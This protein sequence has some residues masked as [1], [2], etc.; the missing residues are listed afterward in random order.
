DQ[1]LLISSADDLPYKPLRLSSGLSDVTI[2]SIHVERQNQA[3]FDID[4]APPIN[5]ARFLSLFAAASFILF[6]LYYLTQARH[7]FQPTFYAGSLLIFFILVLFFFDRSYYSALYFH[8]GQDGISQYLNAGEPDTFEKIRR[9]VFIDDAEVKA[10]L[11]FL[12]SPIW[13]KPAQAQQA[14]VPL[15]IHIK[16]LQIIQKNGDIE[17][18]KDISENIRNLPAQTF[19]LGFLG[20]SQTWGA[21]ASD[22]FHS[23][24]SLTVQAASAL[25]KFPVLG[26]NFSECGT[27][28]KKFLYEVPEIIK[29]HPDLLIVNFGA[30][31]QALPDQ[32]FNQFLYAFHQ[33]LEENKIK[34]L[35]SIEPV[36][37]E[38]LKEETPKAELI[39]KFAAKTQAHLT[40]L[41]K[42]LASAQI[43]NTGLIWQD[44]IHFTNYG[45]RLAADFF[46]NTPELQESFKKR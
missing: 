2:N 20:G 22:Q 29:A 12:K 45:H 46:M 1:E 25:A 41:H 14:K 4:F 18:K 19:K 11:E 5:W 7:G 23:W 34:V 35:Y 21:G 28:I 37:T 39:R 9:K 6:L 26:I 38:S 43:V 32:E 31:D 33:K 42:L 24:P 15:N 27:G 17:F 44:Q 8:N 30:N 3:P 13:F 16:D 40:D 10:D 36:N